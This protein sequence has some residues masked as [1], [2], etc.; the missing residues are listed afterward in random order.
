ME[1]LRNIPPLS[2]TDDVDLT[3]DATDNSIRDAKPPAESD[4]PNE[5]N[6]RQQTNTSSPSAPS[7]S[8]IT[9]L[10][11]T[12][13][14]PVSSSLGSVP[15][16][17]ALNTSI[18]SPSSPLHRQISTG[19]G[20]DSEPQPRVLYNSDIDNALAEVMR[21]LTSLEQADSRDS[22]FRTIERTRELTRKLRLPCAKHTPDLV[23]D[24]PATH[25]LP[26][27]SS[28]SSPGG[29]Q[30]DA[31]KSSADNFAEQGLDT[32]RKRPD[33]GVLCTER[34]KAS[35]EQHSVVTVETPMIKPVLARPTA[36]EPVSTTTSVTPEPME[37][38]TRTS[39][40]R[41][42]SP[43]GSEGEPKKLSI[44]ARV[45]AFESNKSQPTDSPF[46]RSIPRPPVA[47]KP[48]R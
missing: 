31:S 10:R 4:K 37:K 35:T 30:P 22:D 33:S 39:P 25:D 46:T 20:G 23:M 40:V 9:S 41:S 5:D 19:T 29:Q 12:I 32:M 45:A 26:S 13:S 14:Y 18:T 3:E 15:E 42:T 43:P 36:A 8:R 11:H 17:E 34:P 1:Y 6:L 38:Q 27:G 28:A 7:S 44:A 47:P 21:G 2:Q 24:L 16:D 48:R